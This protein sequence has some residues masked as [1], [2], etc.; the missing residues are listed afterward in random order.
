MSPVVLTKAWPSAADRDLLAS[1]L[2]AA[3][4]QQAEVAA[5]LST[6]PYQ[7]LY[8]HAA[9][10]LD[11]HGAFSDTETARSW[12]ESGID[13]ED[14]VAWVEQGYD[15]HQ[16]E[17]LL[18]HLLNRAVS[19]DVSHALTQECAWRTSGLPAAWTIECIQAGV[20]DIETARSRLVQT[21]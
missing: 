9:T 19:N 15:P 2:Y 8:E 1:C 12:H 11:W 7:R 6:S 3:G 10:I 18:D 17:T 5:W 20:R 21:G 4:L 13:I 14:A 16:A